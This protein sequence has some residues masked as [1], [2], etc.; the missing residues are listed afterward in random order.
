MQIKTTPPASVLYFSVETT[1]KDMTRYAIVV[2][3]KLYAEAA[4]HNILPTGP[5]QW[6]YYNCTGNPDSPFTLEIALPVEAEPNQS[7]DFL[8]KQ[9][10]AFKCISYLYEGPWDQ[11]YSKY[12]EII[13]WTKSNGYKMTHTFREVY[14]NL[15]QKNQV[16]EIQVGIE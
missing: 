11:I 12:D 15:D 7:S 3:K 5:L 4:R 9:I 16:T 10:P 2:A 8:F 13:G 1:L 14:L 6:L